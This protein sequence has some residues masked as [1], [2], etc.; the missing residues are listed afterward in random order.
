MRDLRPLSIVLILLP[1][2]GAPDVRAENHTVLAG[3]FAFSPSRLV[4]QAGDTVTWVNTGGLHSV[5]A[6]DGGFTS[7][8]AAPADAPNWPFVH[9]FDRPGIFPYVCVPH[10]FHGMRGVIE[11]E[12]PDHPGIP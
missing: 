4:I 5:L 1:L 2:L 6:D 8:D 3:N 7:G 9:R 10:E 11:V 12:G